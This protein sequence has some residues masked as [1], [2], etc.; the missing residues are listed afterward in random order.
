MKKAA[1][2]ILAAVTLS[3]CLT[4][5]ELVVQRAAEEAARAAPYE[6]WIGRSELE[7]IEVWGVPDQVYASTG[8]WSLV[9]RDPSVTA[10][11][12]VQIIPPDPPATAVR[13]TISVCVTTFYVAAGQ[14]LDWRA[15]G[16]R[17]EPPPPPPLL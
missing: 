17:C 1:L 5:E 11:F 13:L 4:A 3:G 2:V 16:E 8:T 6:V 15:N 9:Y 7:L 10:G 12:E 14:I